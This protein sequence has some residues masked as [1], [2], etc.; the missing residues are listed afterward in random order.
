MQS[1]WG[2]WPPAFALKSQ[3]IFKWHCQLMTETPLEL[4]QCGE[5][6]PLEGERVNTTMQACNEILRIHGVRVRVKWYVVV[7]E[8]SEALVVWKTSFNRLTS[9]SNAKFFMSSNSRMWVKALPPGG[10]GREGWGAIRLYGFHKC[11]PH[12][13]QFQD[14]WNNTRA[15]TDCVPSHNDRSVWRR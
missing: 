2:M 1:C 6:G 12:F 5:F 4:C 7:A 14:W 3:G 15:K 13:L 11:S 9:Q 10:G 8:E